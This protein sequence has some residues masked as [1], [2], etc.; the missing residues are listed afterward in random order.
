M[1]PNKPAGAG[2]VWSWDGDSQ[3]VR[4]GWDE[5]HV[6]LRRGSGRKI[7]ELLKYFCQH[8]LGGTYSHT[9]VSALSFHCHCLILL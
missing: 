1:I 5:W 8:P 6:Q 3:V 4:V 7:S 9:R 2:T